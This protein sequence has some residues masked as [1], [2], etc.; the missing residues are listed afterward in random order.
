V[1]AAWYA[2]QEHRIAGQWGFP[3]D[4][5]WIY[6]TFARNVATGHG[7]SFNPG[8]SV[9][10]ATGPLYVYL[11]AALFAV[12]HQVVW[13]AKILGIACIAGSAILT[14]EAARRMLPSEGSAIPFSAGL[15]VATSA[16]LLWSALSGLELPAYL[17]LLT[18]GVFF[19]A[20]G[21]WTLAAACWSV[22]VWLRPDGLFLVLL[23]LIVRMKSGFRRSGSA[24]LAT[25][26]ILTAF[27]AFNYAVGGSL[28]P[29]TVAVK[30]SFGHDVLHREWSMVTQ[31]L[32]LWG[33]SL[34]PDRLGPHCPVLLPLMVVGAMVSVR[35]WPILATF[36]FGFPLV[37]ALFGPTG[38]Q[39]A[40]YIAPVIPFGFLLAGFG[41]GHLVERAKGPMRL[42]PLFVCAAAVL[43][44]QVVGAYLL[45]IT[46]GWNVQNI[47][48]MHR[49]IAEAAQRATSPGD[50]VAVNDVGAMG[51]FS[52]CYV[53]D[54]V[55]LESPKRSF[56]DNLRT[57][58][59][60]YL[61][62]FPEWFQDYATTDPR[63]G[64]TIFYDADTTYKYLP[65]MAVRLMT[66]T[67]ASRNTMVLFERVGLDDPGFSRVKLVEH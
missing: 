23:Y 27:I 18:L 34:R 44:W 59:P 28:L 53:V 66:N 10:G 20:S 64:Q 43:V 14:F 29:N 48:R 17:L 30:S 67:I 41:L 63:S 15:L 58:R 19:C 5:S 36:A 55:G 4:D 56:P 6:A 45:G 12:F 16:P 9:G 11:L 2:H 57:Y 54:L 61:I 38:G 35:R 52:R 42:V 1:A 31:W 3:L 47:N 26:L 37:F 8:E 25:A 33:L 32:W 22:G 24:I 7:Y 40:R 50:T 39:H 62:V 60:K 13:P 65:F 21:R 49:F 51:Y 46:H